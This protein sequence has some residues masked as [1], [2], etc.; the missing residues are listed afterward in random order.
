MHGQK[1]SE[2][3]SRLLNPDTASKLATKAQQWNTLSHELLSQRHRLFRPP[4]AADGNNPPSPKL[5]LNLTEKML[6]VNPDP[7]HLWNIRRE[8]L[9][10]LKEKGTSKFDLDPELTLTSHCLQRNPKSYATWFHRKWSISCYICQDDLGEEQQTTVA[11]ALQS[12]LDLCA[13]FLMM[14]ERNFHCWNYRRFV[15]AMLGSSGGLIR[16]NSEKDD[17]DTNF[18]STSSCSYTG[19]WSSWAHLLENDQ[20]TQYVVM[21]AQIAPNSLQCQVDNP[22]EANPPIK[23]HLKEL[24]VRE[25]DFTTSKIQDNFSN[26]SAFHYRSKLIPLMLETRL[27]GSE[28][29]A[30]DSNKLVI[31]WDEIILMAREEWEDTLLNAVFTEPDDQT[32]WWY[33]RFIVSW[34]RPPAELKDQL[35]DN[36]MHLVEKYE[37]L[38]LDMADSLR[39]LLEVEKE[40]DVE[41]TSERDESKGVKCK[42][43][44]LGLHLVLLT[45]I[46]IGS[47]DDSFLREEAQECLDELIKIDPCRIERYKMLSCEVSK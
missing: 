34:A 47:S 18:T 12:E 22:K 24:I 42:W 21:G 6:S 27:A 29:S 8:M 11:T 37:S 43:A 33:H 16:H 15:V 10:N 1:R 9:L 14:D 44:Y 45:L 5:L 35:G 23:T 39:E 38:L 13:Q 28:N 41:H 3:K 2:Y 32:P 25:W 36:Y 4:D 46:K 30:N 26:G 19:A 31:M 7:S 20:T 40:N 17:N